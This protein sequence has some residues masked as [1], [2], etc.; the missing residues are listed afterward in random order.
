MGGF[1]LCGI[2]EHLIQA[3]KEKGTK[4]ITVVSNTGGVTDWGLGVLLQTR[5]IKRMIASYVGENK[6]FE[7]L[8]LNG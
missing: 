4:Q 3:V 6:V 8:F 7:S 2:P 5:Q 1:G